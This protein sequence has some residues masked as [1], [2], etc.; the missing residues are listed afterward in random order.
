MFERNAFI[1]VACLKA[2]GSKARQDGIT[3]LQA[4]SSIRSGRDSQIDTSGSCHFLGDGL[5]DS[6]V[7]FVQVDKNDLGAIE[8]FSLLDKRGHGAGGAGTATANVC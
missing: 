6:Q 8:I 4:L 5:H 2:T 1:K 3:V 7:L